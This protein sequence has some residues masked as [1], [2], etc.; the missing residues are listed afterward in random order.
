MDI[1][2][3]IA[4]H[5][6]EW[7]RLEDL[8][9]R[10]GRRRARPAPGELDELV[11]LYQRA[12]SQLSHVRWHYRDP[13]LTQQLSVLVAQA[14]AAIYGRKQASMA[15][16]VRFFT[17]TFPAAVWHCRTAVAVSAAVFF[18]PAL[19]MCLWLLNSPEALEMS[20]SPAD[21]RLYTEELFEQYYSDRSPLQFFAEVTVNNIW[22]SFLTFA[23][24]A[25]GGILTIVVLGVNG[26]FIG[27]AA[28]W[29]ISE[30]E[31]ARFWGF[32]LPHGLLELSAIVIAGAAALRLGWTL[33]APGDRTRAD[34]L[35]EEGGRTGAIIIGLMA[36][37]F[38]AG[39]VEGFITGR[40]FPVG[41]RVGIGA[42]G[43]VAAIAYFV[44]RGRAAQAEGCT[45][46]LGEPPPVTADRARGV[47]TA[48][49]PP[50][51]VTDLPPP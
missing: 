6:L 5:T 12:T 2:R 19:V 30:G 8:A 49:R 17:H 47:D 27:Q 46:R 22:V 13:A 31:T 45:G 43:W 4:E 1:D 41:V 37:F 21:R 15:T 51:P 33:V 14:N 24:A 25:T 48:T 23:G 28:A 50:V 42:V 40:G 11:R 29:M 26:L 16:F 9:T 35:R 39:V 10:L 18:I 44:G 34:A 36:M 7:Q 38:V 3:Y 32:I 20:G